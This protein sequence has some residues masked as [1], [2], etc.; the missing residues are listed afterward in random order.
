MFLMIGLLF[1]FFSDC[2]GIFEVAIVTDAMPDDA[3]QIQSRGNT[4]AG[5]AVRM[6]E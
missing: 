3:T 1:R 2:D 6:Q 5:E 4:Q